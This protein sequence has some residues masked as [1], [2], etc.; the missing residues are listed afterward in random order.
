[1]FYTRYPAGIRHCRA[2]HLLERFLPIAA[3]AL[4]LTGC[5]GIKDA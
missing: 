5:A 4:L 2:A 3:L 1:V